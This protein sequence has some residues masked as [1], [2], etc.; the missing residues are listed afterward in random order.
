MTGYSENVLVGSIPTSPLQIK[1]TDGN[2]LTL[3]I[4]ENN[5]FM[6]YDPQKCILCGRCV[7]ICNE[8]VMAGTIDLTGRGFDAM[9][10]I[11]FSK[12]L[13]IAGFAQSFGAGAGADSFDQIAGADTLFVIGSNTTEAHLD[14]V[15]ILQSWTGTMTAATIFYW[16]AGTVKLFYIKLLQNH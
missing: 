1:N 4:K 2:V 9:P 6:T 12:P 3:P 11:A 16:V 7:R 14:R 15:H 5:P 10:D 8:V 13:S